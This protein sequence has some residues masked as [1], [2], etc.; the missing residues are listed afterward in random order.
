MK[1]IKVLLL[2]T[3]FAAVSFS[4][5]AQGIEA[6]YLNSKFKVKMG[7]T[8]QESDP[9]D[10]FFIGINNDFRL[11]GSWLSIRPGITYS[12]LTLKDET[13]ESLFTI[14]NAHTEHYI[15]IP[16]DVKFSLKL[17]KGFKIYA[18][19]GPT[20]AVGISSKNKMTVTSTLI[21]G[22]LTYDYYNAKITSDELSESQLETLNN[23]IGGTGKHSR[24][25]VLLG[26]GAGVELFDR[27][28]VSF[29]YDWGLLNRYTG[30]YAK[31]N[32]QTREQWM[33]GV[34][35]VF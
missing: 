3:A 12:Y 23:L 28:T 19:G 26:V 27:L 1:K 24:F 17:F 25:D 7:N 20:L 18:E 31:D 11:V 15:N 33:V 34:G 13:S 14:N 4:A 5:K 16:I 29:R 10:G 22:G 21:N 8:T 6:G 35:F 30:D 2:L 9:Y 32:S